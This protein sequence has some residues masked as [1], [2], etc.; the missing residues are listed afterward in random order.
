[1]SEKAIAP[2]VMERAEKDHE[3]IRAEFPN[4][5]GAQLAVLMLGQKLAENACQSAEV[6][7]VVFGDRM[8]EQMVKSALKLAASNFDWACERSA[9]R[10]QS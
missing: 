2:D 4:N 1:M 7:S 6:L 10:A 8:A 3:T 9:R 5:P